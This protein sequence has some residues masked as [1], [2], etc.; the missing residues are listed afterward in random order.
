MIGSL[1]ICLNS[2][3]ALALNNISLAPPSAVA[4][5]GE[6]VSF[7][8]V[9]DFSAEL[10]GG[11]V[12]VLYDSSLL[13]FQS[14]SFDPA[15]GDDAAFRCWPFATTTNCNETLPETIEIGWGVL[16][17]PALT[18]SHVIGTF[19]FKALAN[20]SSTISLAPSAGFPG[21]FFDSNGNVVSAELQGAS[22]SIGLVSIPEPSSALLVVSGLL[23]LSTWRKLA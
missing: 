22:V 23:C 14:F 20:G 4:G 16:F 7:D 5:L 17:S 12:E 1:M 15:L 9:M 18:G 6:S 13:E 2:T 19:L 11:G 8:L 21:P 3:S 10:Q